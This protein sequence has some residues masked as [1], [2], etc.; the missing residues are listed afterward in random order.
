MR[1]VKLFFLSLMLACLSGALIEPPASEAVSIRG[2]P[3]SNIP[4]IVNEVTGSDFPEIQKHSLLLFERY[5]YSGGI[6]Y[7]PRIFTLNNDGSVKK[8]YELA[9]YDVNGGTTESPTLSVMQR[10]SLAISDKRFG[11]RRT[12]MHSTPGMH[13]SS[14][15]SYNVYGFRTIESNGT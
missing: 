1:R 2:K 12:V 5:S 6:R 7:Q 8:Q 9:G 4:D 15:N 10:M 14:G 11:Q 13:D 3:L